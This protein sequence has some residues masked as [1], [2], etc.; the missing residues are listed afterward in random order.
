MSIRGPDSSF[1]IRLLQGAL[2]MVI[3][4]AAG[5]EV[6]AAVEMTA[7]LEM[8]GATLFLTSYISG[9]RLTAIEFWRAFR[10][11]LFPAAQMYVIRSSAPTREKALASAYIAHNAMCSVWL[12]I[13]VVA[14]GNHLLGMA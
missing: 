13:P 6:I 11:M 3:A 4:M 2:A 1:R 12:V 7:L 9:A 14:F 10:A 5:P 8:L